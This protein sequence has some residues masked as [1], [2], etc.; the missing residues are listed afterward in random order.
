MRRS[1]KQVSCARLRDGI[2]VSLTPIARVLSS[3]KAKWWLRSHAVD[4]SVDRHTKAC[5]SNGATSLLC[6]DNH[7]VTTWMHSELRFSH[8]FDGENVIISTSL[9]ARRCS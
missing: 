5:G 4:H 2:P 8:C 6:S 3:C 7:I 1:N 9:Y